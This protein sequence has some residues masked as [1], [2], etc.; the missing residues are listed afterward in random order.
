M[1]KTVVVSLLIYL[2]LG[3]TS[4]ALRNCRAAGVDDLGDALPAGAVSRVG[5]LRLRHGTSVV[6]LWFTPDGKTLL[7]LDQEG[8]ARYWGVPGGEGRGQPPGSRRDENLYENG[9]GDR[10]RVAG[11]AL[12]PDGQ[13]LATIIWEE[14][15]GLP[16]GSRR[17]GSGRATENTLWGC[18]AGSARR[19]GQR[20]TRS[21]HKESPREAL[22]RRQ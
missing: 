16:A 6:K 3:V 12:S 9:S 15:A 19:R 18:P 13:T 4:H 11:F 21:A 10:F 7:S 8:I 5:T 14:D 2:A 17:S 22:K 1:N 20:S